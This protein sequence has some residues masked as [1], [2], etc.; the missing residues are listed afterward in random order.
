MTTQG[1]VQDRVALV[2]GAGSGIGRAAAVLLA[3]EG[4]TVLVADIHEE[5]AATVAAATVAAGGRA[6]ALR[7]DVADE[8]AWQRATALALDHHGRLDILVNNAGVALGKPIVEMT[9]AQWRQVLT[10]NLDGVF[11]GIRH[12]ILAMRPRGG[13]IVNVGS[14]SGIRPF[15]GAAA[16]GASKAAVRLLTRVAA[17]ECQ[18]AGYA[19]RVNAVSPGGVK[20]PMWESQ[21]F[22]RDLMARHGGA[23]EAFQAMAG[24]SPSQQFH[25]AADIARTILYL[26]SDDSSHLTGIELVMDHGHTV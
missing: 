21:E 7:L 14:V 16:Y 8:Q 15:G 6:E 10:V 13:S 25:S 17:I 24:G 19:I 1:K 9:L 4:A 18:D 2:T 22:F 3:A 12:A 20:T 5:S 23:E 26:A 11:L